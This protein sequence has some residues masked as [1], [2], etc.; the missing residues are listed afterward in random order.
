LLIHNFIRNDFS[1]QSAQNLDTYADQLYF[2]MLSYK[3]DASIREF[4]A[5]YIPVVYKKIDS[6]AKWTMYPPDFK[7]PAFITVI[8]SYIFYTHPYFK[9]KFKSG[10]LAITQKIYDD[11]QLNGSITDIKLWFEFDNDKDAKYAYKKLIDT[12]SSFNVL[13]KI[14]SNKG[15]EKAEFTDKNSDN[16]YSNVQI[17][18]VK[19]YLIGKKYIMPTKKGLKT[20]TEPGYKILFEIGNDLY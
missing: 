16:Y 12:F 14:T 7:E 9:E 11:Q 6:G 3:P 10:Q 18:L 20:F 17:V 8:N 19:D 4:I 1:W 2:G 15:V 13:K 5:K